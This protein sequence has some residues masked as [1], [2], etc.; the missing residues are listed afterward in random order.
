LHIADARKN[1]FPRQE[2]ALAQINKL[3]EY[4]ATAE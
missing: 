1:L 4:F 2:W 3:D